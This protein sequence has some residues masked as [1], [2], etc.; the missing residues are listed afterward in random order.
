MFMHSSPASTT[1]FRA[2]P[3]SSTLLKCHGDLLEALLL[4][5][6]ECQQ[7]PGNAQVVTWHL[8]SL[9]GVSNEAHGLFEWSVAGRL[10]LCS[11][12]FTTF[13]SGYSTHV[14]SL[15]PQPWKVK[16]FRSEQ[17]QNHICCEWLIGTLWESEAVLQNY[18][19]I[20]VSDILVI[21]ALQFQNM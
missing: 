11:V 3:G 18:K 19:R 20:S 6:T 8:L 9:L 17:Q 4:V 1:Y 5:V 16:D 7:C 14:F 21:N 13:I 12:L 10:V 15:L 2:L